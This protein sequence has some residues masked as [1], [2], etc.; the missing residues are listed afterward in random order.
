MVIYYVFS[1]LH[2]SL[3]NHDDC[4]YL[5][6]TCLTSVNQF[7]KSDNC[8]FPCFQFH[9]IKMFSSCFFSR[10]QSAC[11]DYCLL[12]CVNSVNRYFNPRYE[13]CP[14]SIWEVLPPQK[15]AISSNLLWHNVLRVRHTLYLEPLI[16]SITDLI[17]VSI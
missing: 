1:N 12:L 15:L 7:E 8:L 6:L 5:C 3:V 11:L 14:E 9:R 4:S 10:F 13:F 17:S 2:I 16:K